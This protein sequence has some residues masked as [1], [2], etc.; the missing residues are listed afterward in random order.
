[1]SLGNHLGPEFRRIHNL[2]GE[3]MKAVREQDGA[4]ITQLQHWI[5]RYLDENQDR[6]IYQKE[7]E[8]VFHSS[9]ATISNTL[10]VMER[11]ELVIRSSVESDARLKKLTLTEKAKEFTRKA[12]EN[13]EQTEAL[14]R[15]GMSEEEVE[16]LLGLLR[17][18]RENLQEDREEKGQC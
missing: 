11:N 1:M 16:Q 7:L 2:M 17:K 3:R 9:R 10:Q 5:I 14:F 12:R 6:E 8:E 4:C 15:R 13:V 18:V